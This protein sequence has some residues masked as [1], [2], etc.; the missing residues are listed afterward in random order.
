MLLCPGVTAAA[1]AAALAMATGH[2]GAPAAQ[3]NQ[4]GSTS[5]HAAA[6]MGNLGVVR[7]LLESGADVHQ[8]SLHFKMSALHLAAMSGG[9]ESICRALVERS[10]AVDALDGRKRTPLMWATLCGHNDT[11]A[12]LQGVLRLS[13]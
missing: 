2:C 8:L 12:F 10:A 4:S 7:F 3:R 1:A 13:A 6:A 5:L 9:G 11:A